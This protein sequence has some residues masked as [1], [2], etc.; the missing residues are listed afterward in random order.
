MTH[1][2]KGVQ[3]KPRQSLES[4]FF[5]F[6]KHGLEPYNSGPWIILMC[7]LYLQA[8][9]IKGFDWF[10]GDGEDFEI[11]YFGFWNSEVA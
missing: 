3:V 8:E 10:W 7:G 11:R 9:F 4:S 6:V 2:G 1:K 5:V